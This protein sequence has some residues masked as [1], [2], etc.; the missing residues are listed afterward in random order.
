MSITSNKRTGHG[1]NGCQQS[2]TRYVAVQEAKCQVSRQAETVEKGPQGNNARNH[3]GNTTKQ[4][5]GQWSRH[6]LP[7]FIFTTLTVS[8]IRAVS[9]RARADLKDLRASF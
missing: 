3:P 2:T 7:V 6:I 1:N 8:V 9:Q 4:G 5:T